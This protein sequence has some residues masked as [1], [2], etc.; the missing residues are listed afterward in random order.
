MV[1]DEIGKFKCCSTVAILFHT[2]CYAERKTAGKAPFSQDSGVKILL[3]I[4][5]A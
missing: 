4:T 3:L 5:V 1:A 2:I